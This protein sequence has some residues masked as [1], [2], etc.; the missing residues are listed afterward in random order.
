MLLVFVIRGGRAG[1]LTTGA[2]D[3]LFVVGDTG[4]DD[5]FLVVVAGDIGAGDESTLVAMMAETGC[6]GALDP[7]A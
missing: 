7:S 5:V 1:G 2:D 3:G 6:V 4:A